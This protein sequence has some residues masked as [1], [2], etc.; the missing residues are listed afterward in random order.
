LPA[1]KRLWEREAQVGDAARKSLAKEVVRRAEDGRYSVAPLFNEPAAQIGRLFVF[2]GV[3]RRVVRIEVGTAPDGRPS[4][5]LER[6]AIDHYYEMEVFSDDS[7]NYPL[8]FCVRELPAGFPT[9]GDLHVPV[10]I[11]G[12]FFKDWLY[13]TRGSGQSEREMPAAEGGERS[14]YAPLLIGK[15]PIVLATVEGGGEVSR[16]VAGGLF[17]LA[18]AGIWAAAVWYARDDRRFRQR[19]PAA[20]YSLPPGQSL[21]ELN[22]P[23]PEEPMKD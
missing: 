22:L 16:V 19:T 21:N 7:Q 20:N 13:R 1:V 17:L 18:L 12:F 2:D 10:R 11:A 23:V 5:V 3:A 8:V 9:G 4:D 14:Q 15:A 6:F